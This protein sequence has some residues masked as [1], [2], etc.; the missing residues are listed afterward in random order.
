MLN[1]CTDCEGGSKHLDKIILGYCLM[2]CD[3]S[4]PTCTHVLPLSD[5]IHHQS[6]SKL[7]STEHLN[8]IGNIC[9][10]DSVPTRQL[11]QAGSV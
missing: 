3:Y 9:K 11:G 7:Q 10:R 5:I 8:K 6:N 4:N 2:I 1:L